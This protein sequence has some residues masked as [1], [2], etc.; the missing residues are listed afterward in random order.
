MLSRAGHPQMSCKTVFK[1]LSRSF[2]L[3]YSDIVGINVVRARHVGIRFCDRH[4][5]GVNY[6][7]EKVRDSRLAVPGLLLCLFS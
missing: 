6:N 2:N 3:T 1:F 5:G 4:P 7:T